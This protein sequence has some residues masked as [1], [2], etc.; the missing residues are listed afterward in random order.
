MN[1]Y[2]LT[3]RTKLLLE[4]ILYFEGEGNYT[5]VYYRDG[6]IILLSK[7]IGFLMERLPE[8]LFIRISRKYAIHGSEL[9]HLILER[10]KRMITFSSGAQ[11]PVARRRMR[12]LKEVMGITKNIRRKKQSLAISQ[13]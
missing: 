11:L 4:E 12:E 10:A 9:P 6:Q 2:P 5:F 13:L 3:D 7:S 1:P 8:G